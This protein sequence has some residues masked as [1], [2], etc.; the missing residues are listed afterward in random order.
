MKYVRLIK[1]DN[2]KIEE[3]GNGTW[4]I[5]VPG[6]GGGQILRVD[7]FST[8]DAVSNYEVILWNKDNEMLPKKYVDTLREAKAI[9]TEHLKSQ[10]VV[11]SRR[12][13][14]EYVKTYT[15]R[16]NTAVDNLAD[17]FEQG[18]KEVIIQWLKEKGHN[19]QPDATW[20]EIEPILVDEVIKDIY[21]AEQFVTTL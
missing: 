8:S 12:H 21:N 2:L 13:S 6:I 5:N 16:I 18:K 11:K 4:E 10:K 14:S 7:K 20:E 17:A 19:Y 1:S 15:A 3:T 9:V